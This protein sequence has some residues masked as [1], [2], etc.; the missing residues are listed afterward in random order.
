MNNFN[1]GFKMKYADAEHIWLEIGQNPAISFE[2]KKNPAP[3]KKNHIRSNPK[4]M[5]ITF[6][7]SHKKL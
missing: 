6:T 7:N 3:G 2:T 1:S 4:N 5:N